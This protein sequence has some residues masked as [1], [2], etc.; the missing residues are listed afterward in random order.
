MIIGEVLYP[1]R[2]TPRK[3]VSCDGCEISYTNT[4]Y[5][6]LSDNYKLLYLNTFSTELEYA[7][8][9]LCHDCF[10]DNLGEVYKQYQ[11]LGAEGEMGFAIFTKESEIEMTYQPEELANEEDREAEEIFME[12]F[13]KDVLES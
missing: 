8:A 11:Q 13:I 3:K 10:F 6:Q 12:D 7:Y 4:Q 5:K 9:V 2:K 1:D